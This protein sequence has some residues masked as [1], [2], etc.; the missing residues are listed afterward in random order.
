MLILS[1]LESRK[2]CVCVCVC[3]Y[4]GELVTPVERKSN[5]EVGISHEED[6]GKSSFLSFTQTCCSDG[7]LESHTIR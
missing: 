6:Y 3:V 7:R 1:W 5:K 2:L 4:G